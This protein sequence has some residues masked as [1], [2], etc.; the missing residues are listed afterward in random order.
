MALLVCFVLVQL[1]SH[2]QFSMTPWTAACQLRLSFTVPWSL[3]KLISIESV[4]LS[5]HLIIYCLLLLLLSIFPSLRVSSNESALCIMWPEYWSLSFSI[6][7]SN[8]YSGSISSRIDSF[9]LAVQGT[10]MYVPNISVH[11]P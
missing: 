7:P 11:C 6:S 8:E 10:G 5:N 3:L 9:D 1:L 2:V 4:M